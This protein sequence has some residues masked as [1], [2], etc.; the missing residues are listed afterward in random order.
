M[1]YGK[2]S[3]RIFLESRIYK[4]VRLDLQVNAEITSRM[5]LINSKVTKLTPDQKDFLKKLLSKAAV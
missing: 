3:T 4:A 5:L 2:A 1:L